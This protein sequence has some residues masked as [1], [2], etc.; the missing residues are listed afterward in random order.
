MQLNARND[1]YSDF[2]NQ[3]SFFAG[4]GFNVTERS[5]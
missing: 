5:S 2:G 4:Y 1:H 3:G